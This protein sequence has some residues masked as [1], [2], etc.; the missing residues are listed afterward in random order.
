MR[1]ALPTD[2]PPNFITIIP[3]PGFS[4]KQAAKIAH[5][6]AAGMDQTV[7]Q[8]L[9]PYFRAFISYSAKIAKHQSNI[10]SPGLPDGHDQLSIKKYNGTSV[11]Q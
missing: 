10:I 5:T 11:Y 3:V 8:I 9:K 2:V 6:E 4:L 1:S 7:I